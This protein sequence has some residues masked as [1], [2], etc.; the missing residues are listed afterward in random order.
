MDVDPLIA[1]VTLFSSASVGG[2]E[3]VM[4]ASE[5]WLNNLKYGELRSRV[6]DRSP[7]WMIDWGHI[8]LSRTDHVSHNPGYSRSYQIIQTQ[9]GLEKH[10][11]WFFH[12]EKS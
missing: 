12:K 10:N 7:H 1:Q 11:H 9:F 4:V 8:E 5:R 3:N 6:A 2:R